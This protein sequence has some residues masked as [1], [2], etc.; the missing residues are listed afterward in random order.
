MPTTAH[1]VAIATRRGLLPAIAEQRTQLARA[2][3][4][5]TLALTDE[6]LMSQQYFD[7]AE[8]G[9][10]LIAVFA[11]EPRHLTD[12]RQILASHRARRIRFYGDSTITDP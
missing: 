10:S 3:A 6:G 8:A 1:A 9:A 2:A 7:E 5:V 12:A 11:P 4:S